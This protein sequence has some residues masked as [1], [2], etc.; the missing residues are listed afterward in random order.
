MS[1]NIIAAF[2]NQKQLYPSVRFT[3]QEMGHLMNAQGYGRMSLRFIAWKTGRARSTIQEHI[4]ILIEARI[5]AKQSF[6]IG[7]KRWAVN[8]YKCLIPFK[9]LSR[10]APAQKCNIPEI[11]RTLPDYK[12][13]E[14]NTSIAEEIRR[15]KWSL[16]NLELSQEAQEAVLKEIARLEA[17]LKE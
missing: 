11:G 2:R 5:L 10:T 9:Q 12:T 6:R 15:Q 3:A 8:L 4:R 16:R 13:E 14:K 1:A 17:L 7:P